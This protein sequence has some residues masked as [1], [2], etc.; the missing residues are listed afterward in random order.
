MNRFYLDVKTGPNLLL[1]FFNLLFS[2]TCCTH[3]LQ[4]LR[5]SC[6][7]LFNFYSVPSFGL[8]SDH[9]LRFFALSKKNKVLWIEVRTVF[10]VNSL[11]TVY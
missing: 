9:E 8:A 3:F 6:T 11:R 10:N 1:V 5:R 4:L 2:R 7:A